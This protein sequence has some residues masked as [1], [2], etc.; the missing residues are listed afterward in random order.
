MH[1]TSYRMCSKCVMDTSDQEIVFDDNGVCSHCHEFDNEIKK[2]WFPN[3]EGK[4]KIE[5]IFDKIRKEGKDKEYDCIIGLSGGVDSSYLAIVMKNYS[6]RPLVVHVDA[7]WNSELA[8]HNIEQVV[9]Y[10][11]YELFTHVVD[12]EEIRD[13]QLAY[14]KA[15]ISNQDVPQDHIFFS[16][17]YHFAVKNKIRYVISGG[18]IATE[19]VIPKSWHHSA[20]D[21]INLHAIH[22]RFGSMPLK[23]YKTISFLQYYFYY[24]FIKK[25]VTIRP[26]NYMPYNKQEALKELKEKIGYKEYGR[27][28]GE[29]R[30]TKFF[31]NHYLPVKFGYDKRRLHLSSQ[32]L[33]GQIS[34]EDAITEL[35]KPLYEPAELN[36]DSVYIAKKLGISLSD[37]DELINA[38]KHSYSEFDNWDKYYLL[39]KKLQS[40]TEKVLKKDVKNYA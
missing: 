15:C 11:G 18:N 8:V 2:R 29:S 33:S 27:K 13:L 35:Q 28:H 38:P 34:R 20:M 23:Q 32:I 39:L 25:M 4:R 14:L 17:L 12:W 9:K 6:L 31:Q 7:G 30:F 26:L 24:P 22:K 36:D 19:S 10:C 21:A 5:A 16:T 3:E 40:I 37:L 1:K